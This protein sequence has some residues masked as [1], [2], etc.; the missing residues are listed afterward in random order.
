MSVVADVLDTL[1]ARVA[2]VVPPDREALSYFA[3]GGKRAAGT[4]A[5]MARGFVFTEPEVLSIEIEN[6][7]VRLTRWGFDLMVVLDN[8]GRGVDAVP[9]RAADEIQ[10]IRSAIDSTPS[11]PTGAHLVVVTE[12]AVIDAGEPDRPSNDSILRL[13]IEADCWESATSEVTA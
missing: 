13:A 8:T 5:S 6:D 11:L 4:S 10:A 3:L 1:S 12:S 7:S 9:G 2:S